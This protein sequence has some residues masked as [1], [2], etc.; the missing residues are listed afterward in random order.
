MVIITEL[1][2]IKLDHNHSCMSRVK[3]CVCEPAVAEITAVK[4]L[5]L[6]LTSFA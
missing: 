4:N 1:L 5:H 2:D 3:F 6:C